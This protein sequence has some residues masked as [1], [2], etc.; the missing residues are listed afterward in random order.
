[1]SIENLEDNLKVAGKTEL[2][3]L[4]K[5][6][7]EYKAKEK[8]IQQR[9]ANKLFGKKSDTIEK[10]RTEIAQAKSSDTCSSPNTGHVEQTNNIGSNPEEHTEKRQPS[11]TLAETTAD[12]SASRQF[13]AVSGAKQ[14]S[15]N[16][17]VLLVATSFAV[18]VVSLLIAFTRK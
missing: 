15:T 17:M 18:V 14:S 13:T 5:A 4:R 3:K 7:T 16:N 11:P 2:I 10:A 12:S 8:E 6:Q 1:M 9:I